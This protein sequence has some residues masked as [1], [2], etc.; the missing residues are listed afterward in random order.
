[1]F[2][3]LLLA[4]IV[5]QSCHIWMS[6]VTYESVMSHTNDSCHIWRSHVTYEW[7]LPHMNESCHIWTSHVTY[8]GVI[9]HI[10]MSHITHK[11]DSLGKLKLNDAALAFEP[12]NS[13][14]MGFG[15]RCKLFSSSLFA[16]FFFSFSAV[17][18][19]LL[20]FFSESFWLR[21]WCCSFLFVHFFFLWPCALDRELG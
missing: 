13:L 3:V 17:C 14:A 9:S 2:H 12:E 1:M 6:H 16:V 18:C 11:G 5:C 10:W 15:F 8:E 20:L 19:F 21:F 4:W 7:E